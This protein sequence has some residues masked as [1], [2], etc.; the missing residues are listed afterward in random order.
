MQ[1]LM[2]IDPDDQLP[3][4]P[5]IHPL[6]LL[7]RWCMAPGR[8]S[9]QDCEGIDRI[10][11]APISSPPARPVRPSSCPPVRQINARARSQSYA[12]SDPDGQLL[13]IIAVVAIPAGANGRRHA[14][15]GEAL[16]VTDRQ[17][18]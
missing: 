6:G 14:G 4:L 2:G 7:V 17:V 13:E 11:H 3:V 10:D 18:L 1:I 12:V 8:T 15:V 16:R 9:G 5:L